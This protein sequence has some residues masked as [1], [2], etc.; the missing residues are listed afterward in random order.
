MEEAGAVSE[1]VVEQIASGDAHVDRNEGAEAE[2]SP[3]R[4]K[5]AEAGGIVL[6][7]VSRSADV[8]GGG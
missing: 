4:G 6:S 2:S 3:G 1:E 5:E 7:D 8:S